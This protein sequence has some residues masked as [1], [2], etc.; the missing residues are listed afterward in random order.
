MQRTHQFRLTVSVHEELGSF[1]QMLIGFPYFICDFCISCGIF[2]MSQNGRDLAHTLHQQND[3]SSGF[4]R[5]ETDKLG[6]R[7]IFH[8]RRLGPFTVGL[9][10][11]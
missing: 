2:S 5:V 11:V 4:L 10:V 7:K 9:T 1:H 6:N 3:I 8:I